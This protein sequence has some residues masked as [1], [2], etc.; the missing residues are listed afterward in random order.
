VFKLPDSL[1]GRKVKRE[2][3]DIEPQ[4]VFLDKLASQK[5]EEVSDKKMETPLKGKRLLFLFFTFLM[6]T[7][8]LFGRTLFFQ[9]VEKDKFLSRAEGNTVRKYL[10]RPS[11]GIIYDKEMNQLV[12]NK[13]SY[14]L[15]CNKRD[16]PI[17][18]K[19]KKEVIEKASS[20]LKEDFKEL[21]EK[22]ESAEFDKVLIFKNLPHEKLILWETKNK[23]IP[24]FKVLENKVREYD[25]DEYLA[26]VIGYTGKI[27]R[28][29]LEEYENYSPVDY[30]GKSGLEK[31]YEKA[32]RGN[33]GILEVRKDARGRF[34]S[35][36]I[37][38]EPESGNNL[39]LSLNEDFQE[40]VQTELKEAME[41]VDS[42]GAT[43][44]AMDPQTGKVLSL[45]SIPTFN[46][47]LFS[48]PSSQEEIENL[49][50]N[51][52]R[53]LFNR[54][55]SGVGYPTG[56]VVKP[57]VAIA[58]LEENII[59]PEKTINC[60]GEIVVENPYYDS[61]NPQSGPKEWVYHDWKTHH[62]TDLQKAIA[63]SCNV[64][65]YT[66]GGEHGDIKGLGARRIKEW[67]QKFGWG[68]K[69]GIDL[70]SEGKGTLPNLDQNWSLGRTYHFSIGQGPFAIPP[71]QV[72]NAFVAIANGGKLLKPQVVDKIV[73]EDKDLVKNIEPEVARESFIESDNV[74]AV[75]RGMRETVVSGSASGWLDSLSVEAA[76]KT[77]TAESSKE[78]HYH[79]WVTVFAPYENP[80][81][82]LTLMIED[83]EGDQVAVLPVAKEVL[84]WY[85]QEK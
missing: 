21:K 70:P 67:I 35:E 23:D 37:T 3:K 57:L 20:I 27:S 74:K 75:R 51:K 39:V 11:R 64:Y 44:V 40:K 29:E 32:L 15:I 7:T 10:I 53:P 38:S 76:A 63:Q 14:D 61:D 43:A 69:T 41:R 24:G 78:N 58:A 8:I 48:Q 66:L 82:V 2:S 79:N 65:F 28:E 54:A 73:N 34:L 77:G 83:V 42:K 13:A 84:N 9:V 56:S 4:E 80:E 6:L 47:N 19:K 50:E 60:T 55:I 59:S 49:F 5:E 12:H 72:T 18:E 31:Y 46:P 16:L 36:E 71:L 22:I 25:Y 30:I 26:H 17:E 33:P 52:E 45:V 68:Y 81:I 62:I 1:R 85:F